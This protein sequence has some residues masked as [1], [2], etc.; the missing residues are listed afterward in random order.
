MS[1]R[2]W[3][4]K[5]QYIAFSNAESKKSA[6]HRRIRLLYF[7]AKT[8][9]DCGLRKARLTINSD[10]ERRANPIDATYPKI[11][12]LVG[13]S[14]TNRHGT[15]QISDEEPTERTYRS[16]IT[17]TVSGGI[18]DCGGSSHLLGPDTPPRRRFLRALVSHL[19]LPANVHL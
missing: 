6:L 18:R 12:L 7:K 16:A 8:G 1:V 17:L 9:F 15:Q 11:G 5:T 3:S 10:D 4:S 19:S 13:D 2:A 14:S